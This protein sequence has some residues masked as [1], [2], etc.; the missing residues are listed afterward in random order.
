MSGVPDLCVCVLFFGPDKESLPLAQR[1]LNTPMRQLVEHNVEFRFGLNAVGEQTRA[2]VRDAV[3]TVFRDAFVIESRE[4][5][6]KYPMM[7]RLFYDKPLT[8]PLTMWFDD[9]SCLAPSCNVAAWLPRVKKLLDIY[10]MIGSVYRNRLLGNQAK[11]IQDQPWFNNVPI[12]DYVK[13]IT[14][15]WWA[16]RSEL[17]VRYAW[18]P[19]QLKHRGGDVMF[20]ALCAQQKLGITHFRDQVWINANE[21]GVESK[22][23]RR[24]YNEKPIGMD[25][26]PGQTIKALSREF[27][28]K[29]GR[30]CGALCQNCP[31]YP[32]Y[33]YGSTEIRKP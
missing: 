1:V 6:F 28:L 2:Y 14:G 20:G 3:S 30:C 21:Q 22:S 13:F 5:L 33:V 27:L 9:D 29:Q 24:G 17:L 18:P 15:G 12:T 16:I 11:W 23:P 25:Y 26:R 4:N 19:P 31:Y 8:A 10:A 7:R 32:P